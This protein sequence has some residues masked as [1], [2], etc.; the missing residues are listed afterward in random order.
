MWMI[1]D[2]RIP[3]PTPPNNVEENALQSFADIKKSKK[4]K[5]NK[6]NKKRQCK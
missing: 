3:Y 4:Q 2:V 6:K 1:T 5:N